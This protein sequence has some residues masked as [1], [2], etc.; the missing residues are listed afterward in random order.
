LKKTTGQTE[1]KLCAL[2][3]RGLQVRRDLYRLS[4]ANG[5]YHYGGS[6]SCVEILVTLYD[7]VLRPND[8]FILSKGH[9]CWAQYVI[10]REKGLTPRLSGHPERDPAQG[11]HASTGSL[12]HGLPTAVGV[13]LAKK[14]EGDGGKVFVLMGDGEVQ[15]GT[16]WESMLIAARHKL[17]NLYVIVDWNRI[18]GSDFTENTLGLTSLALNRIGENLGFRSLQPDGHDVEALDRCCWDSDKPTL[19]IAHTVKGRGVPFMENDPKWHARWVD[20]KQE[21]ELLKALS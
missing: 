21:E 17:S 2:T 16:T 6:F 7:R 20:A 12:G 11:I 1:K 9:A 3:W 18:Q 19:I 15:E 5:G 14:M 8:V 4:K 10:L 13:A